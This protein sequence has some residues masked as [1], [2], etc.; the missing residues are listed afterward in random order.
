MGLER[1]ESTKLSLDSW[2][3]HTQFPLPGMLF[4]L[5][6]APL[7]PPPHPLSLSLNES[8]F[9]KPSLLF[10]RLQGLVALLCAF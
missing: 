10:V 5:F 2:P 6:L 4:P 9:R 7:L 3:L 1:L 8:S